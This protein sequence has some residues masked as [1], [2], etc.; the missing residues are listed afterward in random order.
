MWS[1]ESVRSWSSQFPGSAQCGS[2][3]TPMLSV[4]AV[5]E[6][7]IWL[8]LA[9]VVV[10]LD[11]AEGGT[12]ICCSGTDRVRVSAEVAGSIGSTD[13][14][15]ICGPDG[16]VMSVTKG[17]RSSRTDLAEVEHPGARAALYTIS[18]TPV[19]NRDGLHINVICVELGRALADATPS[20]TFC[21]FRQGPQSKPRCNYRLIRPERLLPR[22]N[23]KRPVFSKV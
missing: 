8:L 13:A 10:R 14:I 22:G 6:R 9:T 18:V 4:E 11:G 12:G 15:S 16:K 5:H 3:V 23:S 19:V 20:R 7:L 17:W 1:S 2:P 21:Q